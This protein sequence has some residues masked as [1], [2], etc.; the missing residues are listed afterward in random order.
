MII[1][2]VLAAIAVPTFIGVMYELIKHW[3]DTDNSSSS[4]NYGSWGCTD[5]ERPYFD[6]RDSSPFYD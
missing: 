2:Y 3:N 4:K 6:D 5:D 1:E